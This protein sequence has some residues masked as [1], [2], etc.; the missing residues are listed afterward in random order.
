MATIFENEARRIRDLD[1]RGNPA[2]QSR[3]VRIQKVLAVRGSAE[4]KLPTTEELSHREKASFNIPSLRL[5]LFRIEVEWLR[6]RFEGL[7]TDERVQNI[8]NILK[9]LS[10]EDGNR[11]FEEKD[12]KTLFVSV[13]DRAMS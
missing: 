12:G 7:S 4:A 5:A 2:Q 1:R 3:L 10:E 11:L 13:R 9:S 6:F 8:N